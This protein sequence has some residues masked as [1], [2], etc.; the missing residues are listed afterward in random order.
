MFSSRQLCR[1]RSTQPPTLLARSG[2]GDLPLKVGDPK[3]SEY[4][5]GHVVLG[6]EVLLGEPA[7]VCTEV[8]MNEVLVPDAS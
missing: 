5:G 8:P 4:L 1:L 6:F 2:F 3:A 7:T